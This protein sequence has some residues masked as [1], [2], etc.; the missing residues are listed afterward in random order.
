MSQVEGPLSESVNEPRPKRRLPSSDSLADASTPSNSKQSSSWSEPWFDLEPNASGVA[1]GLAVQPTEELISTMSPGSYDISPDFGEILASF[2]AGPNLLVPERATNDV[3]PLGV[4]PRD[5]DSSGQGCETS[6]TTQNIRELSDLNL[7]IYGMAITATTPVPCEEMANVTRCLLK[8]LGRVLEASK[9]RLHGSGIPGPTSLPQHIEDR[10]RRYSIESL[11]YPNDSLGST[12]IP[13]IATI[14][15]ILAC[16][17]RLFDLFKETCM[18]LHTHI[19]RPTVAEASTSSYTQRAA[20]QQPSGGPTALWDDKYEEDHRWYVHISDWFLIVA[21][22]LFL[23]AA[24]SL[25]LST[26]YGDGRH[27]IFVTNRRM[28]QILSISM[29][30]TYSG[31]IAFLKLS[32]LALYSSIFPN[33]R[34]N[35]WIRVVSGFIVS[36]ALMSAI[37]AICQCMPVE[38]FWDD[39][40][41]GHCIKYGY[42]QFVATICNIITDFVI[43]LMPI[44]LVRRL[45]TSKDNKRLLHFSFT[46][47]GRHGKGTAIPAAYLS[48]AEICVGFLVVSIPTYRPIY[49]KIVHGTAHALNSD[50]STGP[51]YQVQIGSH[52]YNN[53]ASKLVQVSPNRTLNS[54][55]PGISVT[56]DVELVRHVQRDGTWV[57][58]SEENENEERLYEPSWVLGSGQ[59]NA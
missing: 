41:S 17:Q 46:M 52:G 36:W 40:I 9:P 6:N 54:V 48:E 1:D 47:G 14:L 12:G 49:H 10:L 26:R 25:G 15:M 30:A 7:R 35:Y 27:I 4:T 23:G 31:S 11:V 50:P 5:E 38:S 57:K 28:L 53:T 29:E 32:I 19:A 16:Y 56:E 43:L 45:H 3:L 33:R 39:S 44:P 2:Q 34:F 13:D 58:V 8:I 22:V 24:I 42:L 51:G 37:G 55:T 18:F 59:N 20:Q 21:W